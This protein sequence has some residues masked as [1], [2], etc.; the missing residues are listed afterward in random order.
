MIKKNIIDKI[1]KCDENI[2]LMTCKQ[3]DYYEGKPKYTEI[4]DIINDGSNLILLT[5]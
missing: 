5:Q 3:E 4:V 2:N 1:N